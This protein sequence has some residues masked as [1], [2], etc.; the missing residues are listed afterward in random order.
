MTEQKKTPKRTKPKSRWLTPVE[1]SAKAGRNVSVKITEEMFNDLVEAR[2]IALKHGQTIKVADV[3]R[4][5]LQEAID[6]AMAL[7]DGS[8]TSSDTP[9][10]KSKAKSKNEPLEGEQPLPFEDVK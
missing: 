7:D 8:D 2:E 4:R 3:V 10:A 6:D 5:S 1:P 9:K